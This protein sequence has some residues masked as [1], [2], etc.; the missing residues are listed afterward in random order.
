MCAVDG[1][2][3]MNLVITIFS[4]EFNRVGGLPELNVIA[5]QYSVRHAGLYNL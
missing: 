5:Y 4:P 2:D 1:S 3:D